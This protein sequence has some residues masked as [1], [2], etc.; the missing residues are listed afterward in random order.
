MCTQLLISGRW[1]LDKLLKILSLDIEVTKIEV[2]ESLESTE[3]S[4]S[5]LHA[6]FYLILTRC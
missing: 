1:T 3:H 6:L 5:P 2:F 4:L